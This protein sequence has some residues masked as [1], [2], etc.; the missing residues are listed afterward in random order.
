MLDQSRTSI[1]NIKQI[2]WLELQKQLLYLQWNSKFYQQKFKEF[3]IDVNNI[4]TYEDLRRIPITSKEDL[5]R[6]NEDFICVP[7]TEIIDFVTTSGTLGKPVNLALNEPDLERLALNEMRSF[8]L[9]GVKKEDVVQITTTLDRRFMAGMAYFLGLRK[10]GAGIVRTGSGLPQLQWDSI[11][12][13]KPNYLVAVPSFLLKMIE[14]AIEHKIDYKNSILKA[15]VCIG[16]PIRN[17]DNSLNALGTKIADLWNIEL[18]ST[19]ASTEMAT[20]FTECKFHNGNHIQP[21]L[22]FTEILNKAGG[23]VKEGE[24][25]ELV[26]TTL[27][28]QTMPLLRFATGDI[29]TYSEKPCECGRNTL[30]LSSLIGRKSQMIK[31]KGTTVYPQNII[32]V[33]NGLDEIKNFVIEAK[34]GIAGVDEVIVKIPD[35]FSTDYVLLLKDAFKAKILVTPKIERVSEAKINEL[36]NQKDAVKAKV[37]L[38]HR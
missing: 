21:D 35:T 11:E 20:A 17:L 5:Q 2:Q 4:V 9:V 1:Q 28:N 19:Y 16:E 7:K 30:R 18:F 32:E 8:E 33:L 36:K 27:Q 15:A 6:F 13:F 14:Y 12:R 25:G 37:F 34:K 23:H 10:L 22:I 38:D 31:L 3:D 29:L 24:P 26:I